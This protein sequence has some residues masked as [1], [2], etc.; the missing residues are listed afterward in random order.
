MGELMNL[1]LMLWWKSNMPEIN[2][3]KK[4]LDKRLYNGFGVCKLKKHEIPV[5]PYMKQLDV[6]AEN[7]EKLWDEFEQI[8]DDFLEK[9]YRLWKE[10]SDLRPFYNEINAKYPPRNNISLFPI[11]KPRKER[12]IDTKM[13]GKYPCP[14]CGSNDWEPVL[15]SDEP[16]DECKVCGYH[17]TFRDVPKSDGDV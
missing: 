14:K 17:F 12:K 11:H 8:L 9:D 1:L 4:P 13:I 15:W 5:T 7:Q 3:E 10:H 2:I 16:Y 6:I